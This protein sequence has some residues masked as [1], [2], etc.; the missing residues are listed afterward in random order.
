MVDL[1]KTVDRRGN[2]FHSRLQLEGQKLGV[3]AW[4][5]QVT[6]M[7]P[8]PPLAARASPYSLVGLP[9]GSVF[10]RYPSLVPSPAL[11]GG[12]FPGGPG[13]GRSGSL[14]LAGGVD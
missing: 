6:G 5:V 11:P 1:L 8:K 14:T 3:V 2:A 10:G 13:P 12:N 4:L 7:G 9:R